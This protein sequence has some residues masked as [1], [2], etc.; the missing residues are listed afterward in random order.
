MASEN[1]GGDGR[2]SNLG[3]ATRPTSAAQSY[4][5]VVL[6]EQYQLVLHVR[7]DQTLDSDNKKIFPIVA[8]LPERY[9]INFSSNWSAPFAN[10]DAVSF[11]ADK[12]VGNRKVL[13]YSLKDAITYGTNLLSKATGV[14]TRLKSQ[15]IQIWEGSSPLQ[16]SVDLVF[17]A[18]T[19]TETD[20]RDK[21]MALLK[22]AAPSEHGPGGQVLMQPGPI[23][24]DQVWD[25]N[26]RKI[27]LQVGTYLYLDNVIISSVGSDIETLCDEKGIPIAMTINIEIT[28]FF[29][30][31]TAQD[32][33]RAFKAGRNGG[34]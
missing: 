18:R 4:G 3:T 31:F 22:L 8:A 14:S 16:F 34:L 21:H 24:A 28:S 10:T 13:G 29:T 12:A 27:S 33:E 6:G 1:S 30:S 32:I 7:G 26:S 17:H 5:S 19:N 9:N 23:I 15:S 2:P 25:Q 20:V 11:V